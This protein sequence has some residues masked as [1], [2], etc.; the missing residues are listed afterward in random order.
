MGENV[1]SNANGSKITYQVVWLSGIAVVGLGGLILGLAVWAEWSDGAVIGMLSAFGTLTTG[2]I[3]AIRNQ[4]RQAEVIDQLAR[5]VGAGQRNA[6][7]K[8]E[9]IKRQTNGLGEAD[10]AALAEQAATVAI[11]KVQRAA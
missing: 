7:T 5:S 2:L 9:T 10:R 4:Q 1:T 11:E 3:V 6:D 8:L